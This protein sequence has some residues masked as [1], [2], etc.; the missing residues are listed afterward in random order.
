MSRKIKRSGADR[1][2][3]IG[4]MG[5]GKTRIGKILAKNTLKTFI[6]LDTEIETFSGDSISTI[7]AEKGQAFFREIEKTMLGKSALIP[8]AVISTGGGIIL[9]KDNRELMR[10]T[11]LAVY[12]KTELKVLL[13]R[14]KN[15]RS[16]PLLEGGNLPLNLK[17]IMQSRQKYYEETAH[18]TIETNSLSGDAIVNN[19]QKYLL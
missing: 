18:V 19:I 5:S 1:I 4:M 16:R 10:N 14:L 6:N 3:L 9:D 15:S 11:G 2:Y 17:K 7:F 12:L 8:K 13:E